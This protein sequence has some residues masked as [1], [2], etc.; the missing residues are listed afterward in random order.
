MNKLLANWRDSELNLQYRLGAF[1][2]L[3]LIIHALILTLSPAVRF[4]SWQASYLWTHWIGFFIWSAAFILLNKFSVDHFKRHDQYIIPIV[5]FLSGWGI[6]TV[7]RIDAFFGF[8]QSIWLLVSVLLS[9]FIFSK[10]NLLLILKKY[11]YLLL[12]CALLLATLTFFFGTY[13]GGVGPKL[14]L[15]AGGIFFQ[16]SELLK[17]ILIIYLAAYFSEKDY[18]NIRIINS[19]S[20]T[21]LL[22]LSSLFILIGQQDMGTA[23]I[24]IVIYIFMIYIAFGRKRIIGIGI[25]II[26]LSGV[27]GYFFIDLIRIRFLAWILPWLDPQAG[28]YQIIQSLIAIA[29]GGLFGSGIGMGSPR[30]VPISHS[31]FIYTSLVEETGLIGAI[32]IL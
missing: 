1:S 13:P 3:F 29:A 4:R 32:G 10:D 11:K 21:I 26:F 27:I 17:L 28:S 19:I 31:D 16:P 7:W 8:R 2:V 12:I 30:V 5:S 22:V 9:I 20:P 24:F 15:G 18:P 14:W 25:L 6:L 23:L